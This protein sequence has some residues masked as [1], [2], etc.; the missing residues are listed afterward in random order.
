M[1]VRF[2]AAPRAAALDY[3]DFQSHWSGEHGGL[4]GQIP[5]LRSYVQNH[6]VLD[7]GRPLLP[8]PGFDSLAEL[9]FDSL[10]D[11]DRGFASDFYRSAVV[12]DEQV[13]VDKTRFSLLLCERRRLSRGERPADGDAVKLISFFGIGAGVAPDEL[14]Q[15]LAGPYRAAVA[16]APVLNH[17]QL[18]ELPGAHADRQPAFCAAADLL[19]FAGPQEALA[20]VRGP[21]G[22]RARYELIGLVSGVERLIARPVRIV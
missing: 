12:A 18:L 21:A 3:K 2:A 8:W 7:A 5:G 15:A 10:A 9:E 1:I 16:A 11:M 4:A 19:W 13:L 17:E 20:F 14:N 6:A 22:D